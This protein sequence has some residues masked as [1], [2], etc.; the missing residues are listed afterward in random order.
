MLERCALFDGI[1]PEQLTWIREEGTITVLHAGERFIKAGEV[2]QAVYVLI[3]GH[4]S[5]RI[6][7][8]DEIVL[9]AYTAP[10]SFFG[11]ITLV[12]PGPRSASVVAEVDTELYRLPTGALLKIF[13]QDAHIEACTMRNLAR[14]LARH[15]R[16]ANSERAER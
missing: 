10:G 9:G 4:V 2:G 3:R 6:G 15:L 8:S 1:S 7:E 11:E 5:I 14:A 16:R 13:E 12:D